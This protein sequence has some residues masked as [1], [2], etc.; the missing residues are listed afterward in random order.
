MSN[1]RPRPGV[2]G[3]EGA[4][5]DRKVSGGDLND[6][7]TTALSVSRTSPTYDFVQY[8]S[9]QLGPIAL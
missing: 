1:I 9:G 8:L 5:H 2:I 3:G 6:L 7:K 4:V